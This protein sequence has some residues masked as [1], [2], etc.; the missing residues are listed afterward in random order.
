MAQST[1][2]N[3]VEKGFG[4]YFP[5]ILALC[6][7]LGLPSA[8]LINTASIFY[9]PIANDIAGGT[10]NLAMVSAWMSLCLLSCA[11]F[12]PIIGRW[13]EKYDIRILMVV[14]ILVE[15]VAFLIFSVATAPWQLWVVGFICGIPNTILMG[16]SA[17]VL[18]NRWFRRHVGLLIGICTAF[19]GLGAAIFLVIGQSIMAAVGWRFTYDVWA[20]IALV[21]AVPVVL[22][23]VRN[24]P[25]DR[26][27]LPY[28]T[29]WAVE[30]AGGEQHAVVNP[31][32]VDPKVGTRSIVFVLVVVF[33]FLVSFICQ[34]NGYFPRYVN[35]IGEQALAGQMAGAFISGAVL[36]SVCQVG[37]AC[38]KIGLGIFSDFSV[39]K[40]IAVLSGAGIVGIICIWGFPSTILMPIGGLIFGLF[41]AGVLVL[42]PMLI[43]RVFGEGK[44][45]PIF[46]GRAGFFTQLGGSA[47]NLVWPVLQGTAWG[48]N[49]VFAA[50]IAGI[51]IVFITGMAVYS[52]RDKLPRVQEPQN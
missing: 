3:L 50:A 38:G 8:M 22:I 39:G 34:I 32:S 25:S 16:M 10:Q 9:E 40:A 52:M 14:S 30:K 26:G 37:S 23:C 33:G 29:A 41:I 17:S 48:F 45:F 31:P 44:N 6:V 19:A 47:A 27:L 49:A 24:D 7:I 35:W 46:N 21:V 11:L 42:S 13:M 51:V 20:I 1:K 2:S 18:I 5:I 36:A 28:G 12:S 4:S 43:R 15:V